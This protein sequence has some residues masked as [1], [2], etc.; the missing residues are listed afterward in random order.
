MEEQVK[1]VEEAVKEMGERTDA[2]S[3]SVDEM[4]EAGVEMGEP[5]EEMVKMDRFLSVG[6]D[7]PGKLL[8]T[9]GSV[10]IYSKLVFHFFPYYLNC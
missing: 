8:L 7:P 1:E 2:I 3:Y 6:I 9:R 5:E 10:N 4:A